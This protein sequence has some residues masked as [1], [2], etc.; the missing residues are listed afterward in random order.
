[1][2]AE[3]PSSIP[4]Y[5]IN[6]IL[7]D[8]NGELEVFFLGEK[9][10]HS[11]IDLSIPYKS[12]Y[13]KIGI[14]TKGT[15]NLK[16][17][18]ED[19]EVKK[20]C[21]ML[22]SPNIIKQWPGVSKDFKALSLFF[23][24][25]FITSTTLINFDQFTFLESFSRHVLKLSNKETEDIH[26]SMLLLQQ[27]YETP[28]PYRSEILK[29]TIAGL[30]FEIAAIYNQYEVT[31]SSKQSR[32][33]LLTRDFKKLVITYAFKQRGLK[34]YAEKLFIS[35]KHL[36]ETVKAVSGK[37][38]GQWLTEAVVLQAKILLQDPAN[39][40]AAISDLLHFPDQ[41]TFSKFF[42]KSSG[43]SPL[44]YKQGL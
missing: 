11:E 26:A 3:M 23:T 8:K 4:T 29:T 6:T 14:C 34:F 9:S 16:V 36:T 42:K 32:A 24:R 28:N 12:N 31:A 30:L 38:A 27:K 37:T 43:Y 40:V 2:I 19:Y 5:G 20:N 44:A 21:L 1:M 39:T 17:N 13:Y 7:N 15:A 35:P 18:L 10:E 22:M 33:Q 25:D 41:A